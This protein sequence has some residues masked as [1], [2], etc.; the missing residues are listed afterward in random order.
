VIV[1]FAAGAQS[2]GPAG[3]LPRFRPF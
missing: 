3:G 1:G 2:A